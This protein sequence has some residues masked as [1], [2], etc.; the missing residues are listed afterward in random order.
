M[1]QSEII[2]RQNRVIYVLMAV[3]AIL[4]LFWATW[5]HTAHTETPE[6]RQASKVD[7]VGK[8]ESV[9]MVQNRKK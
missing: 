1:K 5:E 9:I 4:A 3:M 2:P 7:T 6:Q 8:G